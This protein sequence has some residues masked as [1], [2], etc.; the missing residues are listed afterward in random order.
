MGKTDDEM[1]KQIV[2]PKMCIKD[3]KRMEESCSFFFQAEDG[4]R[5]VERSRGLGDVNKRQRQ[6]K[7]TTK[8]RQGQDKNKTRTRQGQDKDKTRTRQGQDKHKTRTRQEK[9]RT[10]Q[11]KDNEKTRTNQGQE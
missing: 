11:G 3:G 2:C 7:E 6:D 5:D 9:T 1:V 10:R 8:T 4:I